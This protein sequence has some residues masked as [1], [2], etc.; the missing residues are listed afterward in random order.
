MIGD[1]IIRKIA[2]D[3]KVSLP[4]IEK[5]YV[6]GWMLY[7]IAKSSIGD[8]VIF[9]G[10]T[11]LS[12]IYFPM[13]WRI[14]EDLD[15]TLATSGQKWDDFVPEF[16]ENI[17]KMLEDEDFGFGVLDD[18]VYTNEGFLRCREKYIGPTEGRGKI[19]I[20]I[21]TEKRIGPTK[22]VKFPQIPIEYDYPDFE[23][24]V[25]TL[26]N[27]FAEKLRSIIERGYIRDY[28][29][30]WRLLKEDKVSK[31]D[32]KLF[33]QK[34]GAKGIQYEGIDQ[35]FP[36]GIEEELEAYKD[37]VAR[38]TNEKLDIKNILSEFRT[39][40]EQINGL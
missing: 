18:N 35:F 10:G 23:V 3:R 2:R 36:E 38:M 25:Y 13:D 33:F 4:S 12:K 19:K 26:E 6:L 21:G 32:V 22:K 7:G 40:L 30:I 9:K 24:N 28:Y 20:E 14:S 29:D 16:K 5:D 17:P 27:I 11:S 37:N 15:F 39:S 1:N 8:K 34:C 31:P